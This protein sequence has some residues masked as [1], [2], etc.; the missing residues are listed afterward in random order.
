MRAAA[1]L[2]LFLTA[3]ASPQERAERVV[4]EF[5]PA[6]QAYGF[7]PGTDGYAACLQREANAEQERYNAAAAV[8]YRGT[9][10][11]PAITCQSTAVGGTVT[12]SCK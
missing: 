9:R 3:C 10:P 1:V 6:C 11:A 2:V 12:T 4:R 5:G 8:L 7:A